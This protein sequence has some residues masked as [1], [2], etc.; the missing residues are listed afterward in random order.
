[1]SKVSKKVER[2]ITPFLEQQFGVQFVGDI[3]INTTRVVRPLKPEEVRRNE[4]ELVFGAVEFMQ[5]CADAMRK[6]IE[7]SAK[8]AETR[9]PRMR[10][11]D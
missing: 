10:S 2:I 8:E 7:E 1:M 3:E 11:D 4:L 9:T 6:L 5:N